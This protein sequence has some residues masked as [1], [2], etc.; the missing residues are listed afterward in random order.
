[1]AEVGVDKAGFDPAVAADHEGGR[2]GQEPA[3]IPLDSGKVDAE[4][5]VH[6]HDLLADP[7]HEPQAEGIAEIHVGEHA[8]RHP[9]RCPKIARILSSFRDDRDDLAS[10]RD[11]VR[12]GAG[13][14]MKLEPAIVAPRPAIEADHERAVIKLDELS[15]AV[16]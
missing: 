14:R 2:D 6:V 7:E 9:A 16:G 10:G 5:P 15:F 12:I 1:V 11:D 4:A 13:G 3:A 8:E